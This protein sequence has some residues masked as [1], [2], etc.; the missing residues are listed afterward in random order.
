MN[1]A[2]DDRLAEFAVGRADV[3]FTL[4]WHPAANSIVRIIMTVGCGKRMRGVYRG[5]LAA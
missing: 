1:F 4:G 5:T 2:H 3:D